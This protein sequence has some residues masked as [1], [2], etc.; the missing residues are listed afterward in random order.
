MSDLVRDPLAGCNLILPASAKTQQQSPASDTLHRA[1]LHDKDVLLQL[2]AS[3]L[4][5]PPKTFVVAESY[6]RLLIQ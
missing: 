6:S 3:E 4:V 1:F 5:K 2:T